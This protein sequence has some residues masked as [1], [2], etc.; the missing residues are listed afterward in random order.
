M[1]CVEAGGTNAAIVTETA[2]VAVIE[3]TREDAE[4]LALALRRE[5]SVEEAPRAAPPWHRWVGPV[6]V[7]CSEKP[8]VEQEVLAREARERL[9]K[10][11]R[12]HTSRRTA[13]LR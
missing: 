3:Q 2:R 1:A 11:M 10:R 13:S 5:R 9:A 6:R 7:G 12:G 8:L 4:R